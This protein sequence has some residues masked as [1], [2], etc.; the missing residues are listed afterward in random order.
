ERSELHP[1]RLLGDRAEHRP[2]LEVLAVGVAV[3]REEVVPVEDHVDAEVF[4]APHGI[5]DR[6]VIG[7][8]GRKLKGAAEGAGSR[9]PTLVSAPRPRWLSGGRAAAAE[10]PALPRWGPAASTPRR[11]GRSPSR[12]PKRPR[13]SNPARAPRS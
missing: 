8:R 10:R 6:G 2:G 7:V 5:P 1:A 13:A 11:R 9:A 12:H 3:E 4:G